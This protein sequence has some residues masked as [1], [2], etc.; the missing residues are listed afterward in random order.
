[1]TDRWSDEYA[2][3]ADEQVRS[4]LRRRGR[5]WTVKQEEGQPQELTGELR[6]PTEKE[7]E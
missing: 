5:Q 6:W 4:R 1:M 2:A 3:H 7:R